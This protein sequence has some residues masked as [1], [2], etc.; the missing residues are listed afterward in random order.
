[1]GSNPA[2]AQIEPD[3]SGAPVLL[4]FN[5]HMHPLTGEV[6]RAHGELMAS[7]FVVI[8]LDDDLAVRNSL[9]FSLEIEGF[10]VRSYAT[11]AA[12]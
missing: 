1:M 8:V 11:A 10:T 2:A 9:K 7:G 5:R 4:L 3:Q 6:M 12:V